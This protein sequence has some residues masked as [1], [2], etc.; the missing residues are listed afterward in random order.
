MLPL[1]A[2]L[3]IIGLAPT[4]PASPVITNE[5]TQLFATTCAVNVFTPEKLRETLN[6][7]LTPTL[8]PERAAPFLRGNPGTAWEIHFGEGQ[9]ALTLMDSGLC[10]VFARKATIDQVQKGFVELATSNP[11]SFVLRQI[12]SVEAGPNTDD[13][14]STAYIWSYPK[15]S[16][17]LVFTLTTSK[18]A[19]DP[20]IQAMASVAIAGSEP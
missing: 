11:E 17:E 19:K 1:L 13:L 14:T 3:T 8:T 5:F 15:K 9:Y 2:L 20:E 12:P 6:S 16:I 7:P 4:S 18:A 10:A